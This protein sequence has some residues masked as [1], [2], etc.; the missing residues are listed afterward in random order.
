[1]GTGFSAISSGGNRVRL[2]DDFGKT[3]GASWAASVAGTGIVGILKPPL[4]NADVSMCDAGSETDFLRRAGWF[5]WQWTRDGE[6]VVS[7]NVRTEADWVTLSYR[8]RSGGG[9]WQDAEYPVRLDRTPCTYGGTRAWFVCP[10]VRCG[11]RV[12]ILYLGGRYFACRHCYRLAY[13]SQREES[14][15]RA[16]RR[17]QAIRQR[18]GGTANML[19]LFP[20]KP[21]GM[22]WRTYERLRAEHNDA[23][24]RSWAG[25]AE[26]FGLLR[27]ITG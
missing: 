8:H 21:K 9:D 23:D 15:D 16:L 10:A 12:A 14:H 7:I 17:A 20:A 24:V 26:K 5:G 18:L 3:S 19:D 11:R 1:M 13:T 6:T 22:R 4:K 25:I 2:A 27:D